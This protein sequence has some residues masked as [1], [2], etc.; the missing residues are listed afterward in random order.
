[1]SQKISPQLQ[2][3]LKQLDDLQNTHAMVVAQRQNVETQLLEVRSAISELEKSTDDVEVYKLA[4]T[5]LVKT[6][7]QKIQ[8]ELEE[9]KTLLEARLRTLEKQDKRLQEEIGTLTGTVSQMLRREQQ[10]AS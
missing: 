10:R 5:V 6:G 3:H 8:E 7:R 4:G 2:Q 9:N 1:M